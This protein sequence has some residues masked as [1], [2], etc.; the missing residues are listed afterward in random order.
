[1]DS[2]DHGHG[3][4]DPLRQPGRWERMVQQ[5]TV[6]A[7]PLLAE[8]RGRRS[9]LGVI[10][11]WA[12]PA[13]SVAVAAAVVLAVAFTWLGNGV[14]SIERP[15]LS[16]AVLPGEF[17]AWLFTGYEPTVTELVTALEGGS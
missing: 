4:L 15:V 17:A 7:A 16:E 13:G 14:P 8:R 5:I 10:A 9:V 1:M 6:A 3:E 12:R 2:R 11:D